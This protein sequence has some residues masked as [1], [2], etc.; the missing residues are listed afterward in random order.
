V[1]S[2]TGSDLTQEGQHTDAS[3][4]DFDVSK[5]FEASFVLACGL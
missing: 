1:D 5:T 4:L 3:V 2:G